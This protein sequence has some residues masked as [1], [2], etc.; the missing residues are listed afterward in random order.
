MIIGLQRQL[1]KMAGD[2]EKFRMKRSAAMALA[3]DDWA[4]QQSMNQP[5]SPKRQRTVGTQVDEEMIRD[6]VSMAEGQADVGAAEGCLDKEVDLQPE[7]PAP[8]PLNC[9]PP[10]ADEI[11]RNCVAQGGCEENEPEGGGAQESNS[12]SVVPGY[13]EAATEGEFKCNGT[14]GNAATCAL[15]DE[16]VMDE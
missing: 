11:G 13:N 15:N 1:T 8:L 12:G 5:P 14:E 7:E 6:D 10:D 9:P 2:L 4:M 3:W 16:T